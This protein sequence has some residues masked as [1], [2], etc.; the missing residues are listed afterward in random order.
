MVKTS[1]ILLGLSLALAYTSLAPAQDS[2]MNQSV[3]QVLQITREFLKPGKSGAPHDKTESA[4]VA[5][6]ARAKFPAHYVGMNSMSGKSRALFLTEYA[7][8][9][10]WEK[11]NQ[12]VDKNPALGAELDRESVADG[13]LLDGLDSVVCTY[14]AELS[15]HPHADISHARYMEISVYH[16]RPG[17][18]D[19]W[20]ELVKMV[21]D[22]H[23]KAGTSAHW[24]TFDMA[25]GGE[26]GTYIILS[27]DKSMTEIDQGFAESKKFVEGMGGKEGMAKLDELFGKTVDTSHNELFSFNPKQ[28]YVDE[29][30]I[31]ADP[32]FWKPKPAAAPMAKPA[33]KTPDAKPA[34][35]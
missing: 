19:D 35:H 12:I 28:S 25:Y 1:P 11:D 26:G 27:A 29:S 18:R 9:A 31:K 14:N 8:F 33:A 16:V 15:Y 3:P 34:A 10:E 30:W 24:A 5:T 7:S 20:H 22:A 21:K 13:E 6:M 17:H 23:E 32:E 2:S 4:F